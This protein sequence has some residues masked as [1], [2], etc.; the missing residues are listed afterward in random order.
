[1]FERILYNSLFNSL[2]QSDLFS[3][4]QYGFKPVHS[5]I[6]PNLGGSLGVRFAVEERKNYPL[7]K[8][9]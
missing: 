8:T 4:A 1:M 5:C 6:I 2:N 3:P 7:F 9:R